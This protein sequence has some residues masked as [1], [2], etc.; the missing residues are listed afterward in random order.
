MPRS[1]LLLTLPAVLIGGAALWYMWM[2]GSARLEWGGSAPDKQ[3]VGTVLDVNQREMSQ[4]CTGVMVTPQATWL[5]GRS[6]E[7]PKNLGLAADVIDLNAQVYGDPV[8]PGQAPQDTPDRSAD[9][10]RETTLISRLEPNGHFHTLA[11]VGGPACLIASPDGANVFLLTGLNRPARATTT[12]TA[13]DQ[14]VVLRSEDQGK[15]WRWLEN[16][17]FP[18]A[19]QIASNL[20]P[21]FHGSDEVWAWG[22]PSGT[23]NESGED[24]P[25]AIATGVFY[26]DDLGTS[27]TQLF[28]HDS[29]LVSGEYARDKRPEVVEWSQDSGMYGEIKTHVSQ[30]DAQHAVIWV[31]QSF[32]G[33]NPDPKKIDNEFFNVTTQATARRTGGQWQITSVQHDDG[34]FIDELAE[35]DNGRIMG[36]IAQNHQRNDVIAELDRAK[37]TWQPQGQLP[38]PFAPLASSSIL[39]EK[40]FFVGHDTLLINTSSQHHPARWLSGGSD[41]SISAEAVFYSKDWGRS[42]RKLAIDGY[43][44]ILGFQGTQD[45]V[46]WAKADDNRDLGVYAYGLK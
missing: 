23:D 40:N 2:I 25:G 15:S 33:R 41:A 44:G 39:R 36:L 13:I 38:S 37:L 30:L 34:L 20:T 10:E 27:S 7:S 24:S 43:L 26:S 5:I 4:Y 1:K 3:T 16:G 17:L 32:R 22:Y 12:T 42:W 21:W 45:R 8:K 29:L 18:Q 46:I 9:G 6:E 14:T 31:S 19:N 35:N 11:H 28:A